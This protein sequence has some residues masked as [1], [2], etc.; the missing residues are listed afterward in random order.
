[1]YLYPVNSIGFNSRNKSFLYTAGSDGIIYFWDTESK[2]KIKTFNYNKVPITTAAMSYDGR[3]LAYSL[4]DDYS[5]GEEGKTHWN[6][7]KIFVHPI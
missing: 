5:M 7:T 1:M 6:S 2:N 4:G 3:Y